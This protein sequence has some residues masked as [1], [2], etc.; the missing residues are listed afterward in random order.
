MTMKNKSLVNFIKTDL[1]C[2][3]PEQVFSKIESSVISLNKGNIT[4]LVRVLV[5]ERL[6]IY[7]V[8]ASLQDLEK[9]LLE[10][11]FIKGRAD[12]D[13]NSYNRFRLVVVTP[14][15]ERAICNESLQDEFKTRLFDDDEKLHLHVIGADQLPAEF[16]S[17]HAV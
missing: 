1:G 10:E 9:P 6:L 7:I 3:C 15:A 2:K 4:S 13:I 14:D 17:D 16:Q 12:R 8:C 5:G 11:M